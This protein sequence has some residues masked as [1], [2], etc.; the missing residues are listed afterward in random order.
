MINIKHI[1]DLANLTLSK[2]E[3]ALYKKQLASVI[4]FVSQLEEVDTKDVDLNKFHSDISNKMAE[5]NV[6]PSLSVEKVVSGSR[7]VY[8]NYFKVAIVLK[9][10]II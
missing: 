3:E 9:N 7:D 6:L 5:D 10:K 4:S 1:A 8:N 2:K